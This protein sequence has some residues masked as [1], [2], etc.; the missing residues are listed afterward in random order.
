MIFSCNWSARR[1]SQLILALPAGAA[2]VDQIVGAGRCRRLDSRGASRRTRKLLALLD[3]TTR[4][5]VK[6]SSTTRRTKPGG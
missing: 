1:S 4:R 5:E 3:D 2:A 6:G